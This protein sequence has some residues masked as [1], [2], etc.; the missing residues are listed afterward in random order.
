M[1]RTVHKYVFP[2]ISDVVEVPM[3][4]NA[5]LLHIAIQFGKLAVW[6]LI[7][8]SQLSTIRRFPI[9][10]TGHPIESNGSMKHV[11]SVIANEGSL[12]LHVFDCGEKPLAS[13]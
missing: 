12:V 1:I 10:G 6:A 13:S 5:H 3:P 11:G 7:A 8:E 9:A 4:R 2:H